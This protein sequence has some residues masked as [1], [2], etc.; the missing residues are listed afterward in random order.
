MTLIKVKVVSNPIFEGGTTH[1]KGEI[2]EISADRAKALGDLVVDEQEE[3]K[4]KAA[5]ATL[6]II[7][8][9]NAVAKAEKEAKEKQEAEAKAKAE[10]EAKEKQQTKDIKEPNENKEIKNAP[11]TKIQK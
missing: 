8:E 1:K 11:K 2:I 9:T 10:K 6:K 3:I 7:Q 5:E 4:R